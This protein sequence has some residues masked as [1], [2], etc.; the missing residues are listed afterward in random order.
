MYMS[1][2]ANKECA[3]HPV[4][5]ECP[6]RDLDKGMVTEEHP[7][8]PSPALYRA[9]DS[10]S[11]SRVDT[12][13][14]ETNSAFS[15]PERSAVFGALNGFIKD[16]SYPCAGAKSALNLRAYR[17]GFYAPLGS[18]TAVSESTLDAA[19]F[20]TNVDQIDAHFATFIAVFQGPPECNEKE[21]SEKFWSH[22][23]AM[24]ATDQKSHDWDSEVSSDPADAEFALSLGGHA[25]FVV[26]MHPASSRVA[27]RFPVTTLVFNLHS[28]FE[29]LRA[30]SNYATMRDTIRK[31]D[32]RLQGVSNPMLADFGA[33][34]AALQYDGV[35]HDADWVAPLTISGNCPY[36][37]EET[38][39]RKRSK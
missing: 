16:S 2:K 7:F 32:A 37:P 5:S 36:Q 38:P 1:E 3:N 29:A 13:A 26:G 20:A 6:M 4:Q 34:S 17:M 15:S 30:N 31:R 22:L 10:G 35:V 25:F 21:F 33:S 39:T 8:N 23:S 19:W 12:Q 27:R 18:D 11:L 24:I 9:D 14:D 28:Q